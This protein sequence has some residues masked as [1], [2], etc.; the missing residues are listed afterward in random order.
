MIPPIVSAI[1][2]DCTG[3]CH[4]DLFPIQEEREDQY[5]R[6]VET[7]GKGETLRG[8][9]PCLWGRGIP[10]PQ[11]VVLSMV[12]SQQGSTEQPDTHS[13][14]S[15]IWRQLAPIHRSLPLCDVRER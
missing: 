11:L 3:T 13:H 12:P 1:P 5:R 6:T 9:E 2:V 10:I 14:V 15:I 7:V 8:P 4:L